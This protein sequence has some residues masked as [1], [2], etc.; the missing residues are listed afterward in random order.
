MDDEMILARGGTQEDI[1]SYAEHNGAD[2]TK[3]DIEED[4]RIRAAEGLPERM[5]PSEIPLFM[6]NFDED[7]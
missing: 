6:N 4:A 5:S 1:D 7:Y 2:L 3:E